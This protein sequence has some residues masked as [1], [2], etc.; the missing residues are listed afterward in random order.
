MLKNSKLLFNISYPLDPTINKI[1][2]DGIELPS[3]FISE[4][5][6]SEISLVPKKTQNA[7]ERLR[8]QIL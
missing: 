7:N 1:L 6:E 8:S 5:F 4:K 2:G 3:S